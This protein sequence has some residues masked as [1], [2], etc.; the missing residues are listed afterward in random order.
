MTG[1][2]REHALFFMYGQGGNGGV[3]LNTVAGHHGDINTVPVDTFIDLPR[4]SN[5]R[6]TW[7]DCAV[8]AW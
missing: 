3:P 7:P 2:T 6:P 4:I 5:T 1:D 8:R